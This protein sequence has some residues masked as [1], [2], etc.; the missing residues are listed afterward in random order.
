MSSKVVTADWCYEEPAGQKARTLTFF[1]LFLT[2]LAGGFKGSLQ[3]KISLSLSQIER[4]RAHVLP[5]FAS[6]SYT[7]AETANESSHIYWNSPKVYQIQ[8]VE[9]KNLSKQDPTLECPIE[10]RV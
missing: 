1:L 4:S 7:E 2:T 5:P 8:S 9:Q 6:T 3:N 10:K